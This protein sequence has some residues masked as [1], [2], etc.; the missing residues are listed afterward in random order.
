M[1][2]LIYIIPFAII[3]L[4]GLYIHIRNIRGEYRDAYIKAMTKPLSLEAESKLVEQALA[5]TLFTLNRN[6]SIMSFHYFFKRK[7]YFIFEDKICYSGH[8]NFHDNCCIIYPYR[9][10]GK[11]FKLYTKK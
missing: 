11:A 1:E 9:P 10:H 3:L 5:G 6:D 7:E 2:H 4:L 8:F